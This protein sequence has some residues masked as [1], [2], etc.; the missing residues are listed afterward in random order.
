VVLGDPEESRL[1]PLNEA[2]LNVIAR[3]VDLFRT[4]TPEELVSAVA[5][6]VPGE[7]LWKY[8]V[9]GALLMLLG[10]IALTRWI[11]LRRRL[12]ATE[13]VRFGGAAVDVRTFRERARE[14]LTKPSAA[15]GKAS[16]P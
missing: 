10:E 15:A 16:E 2:D 9:I 3:H 11:T 12:H 1:L 13:E 7:E 14:L 6:G 8:L 4:E 5:G